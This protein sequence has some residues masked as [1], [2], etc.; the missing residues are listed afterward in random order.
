MSEEFLCYHCK[1]PA[2]R[3]FTEVERNRI[4]R[5]YLCDHCPYPVRYFAAL[6]TNEYVQEI[7]AIECGN[8]KTIWHKDTLFGCP[9]CYINFHAPL[10]ARFA[11][12]QQMYQHI[13][14]F[15][16]EQQQINPKIRLIALNEALHDT[17]V[18][19]DYEQAAIIR[20]Q[21]NQIK[22]QDDAI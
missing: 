10:M 17:L 13:G 14:R 6:P 4:S 11:E 9:Q 15:P 18:K 2:V 8:C 20:D 5:H 21:I 19:E 12:T 1:R 3:S 22:N 7:L 16:G